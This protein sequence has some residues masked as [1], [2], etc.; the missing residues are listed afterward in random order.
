MRE[1][2]PSTGDDCGEIERLAL[3][4]AFRDVEH[5]DVAELTQSDEVGERSADLAG[6][7][8]SNLGT[9]HLGMNLYALE[10]TARSAAGRWLTCPAVGDKQALGEQRMAQ[11]RWL[12]YIIPAVS[13]FA[14]GED[15]PPY[16]NRRCDAQ[17]ALRVRTIIC[18][19]LQ[20]AIPRR[21]AGIRR[22]CNVP[23]RRERGMTTKVST[24]SRLRTKSGS[25]RDRGHP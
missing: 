16:T 11:S 14:K 1:S 20:G 2:K 5:H 22:R 21:A 8:Q 25:R 6:A 19:S 9:R 4:N 3:R 13:G 18:S 24:I 15:A 23:A 7:D 17:E 12:I 10:E